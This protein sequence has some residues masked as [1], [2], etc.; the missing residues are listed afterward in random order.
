MGQPVQGAIVSFRSGPVGFELIES[1]VLGSYIFSHNI[2]LGIGSQTFELVVEKPGIIG[3][4]VAE[5]NFE[6]FGDLEPIV[7]YDTRVEG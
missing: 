3:P 6:V 5:V 4:P 1:S 2:T 7:F